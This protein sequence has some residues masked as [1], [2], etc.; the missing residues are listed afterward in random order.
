M[1]SLLDHLRSLVEHFTAPYRYQ[2]FYPAEVATQNEDGTLEIKALHPQIA[3]LSRI[4]IRYG[5]PAVRAKI[6]RGSLVLVGYEAADPQR[7]YA[8]DFALE[9][10]DELIITVAGLGKVVVN[11]DNIYLGGEDGAVPIARVGDLLEAVVP[12]PSPPAGP[13]PIKIDG[14]IKSASTRVRSK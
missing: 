3:G 4:P 11:A 12:L 6:R 10:I 7:P 14:Y 5:V 13:G 9:A 8:T 1:A 2:G